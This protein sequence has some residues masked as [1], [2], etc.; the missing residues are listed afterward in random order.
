[1]TRVILGA[2][3][4]LIVWG[5][6]LLGSDLAWVTVSPDWYGKYQSEL[7]SA[8][9]N[10]TPFTPQ[11]SILLIVVIRSVIYSII[12]GIITAIIARDNDKSTL[13]LGILLLIFGFIIHSLFWDIVP[14]WFHF[15]ILF[16]LIPITVFGG[17]L[18]T[19]TPQ[20]RRLVS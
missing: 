9:S 3:V 15:S 19:V 11:T 8:I 2:L 13:I 17:K 14:F 20:R 12:A 16:F 7:K 5:F 18:I 6:F 1:M 4:G 10:N